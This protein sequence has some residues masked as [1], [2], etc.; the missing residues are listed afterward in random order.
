MKISSVACLALVVAPSATTAWSVGPSSSRQTPKRS[1]PSPSV[2]MAAAA[3]ASAFWIATQA[4]FGWNGPVVDGPVSS[5][6]PTSSS[7]V[8]AGGAYVPEDSYSSLD[9]SMPKYNTAAT[10]ELILTPT[11]QTK[12]AVSAPSAK[13]KAASA[14]RMAQDPEKEAA[15]LA[16]AQQKAAAQAAQARAQAQAAREKQEAIQAKMEA[17]KAE[18]TA[19]QQVR[20]KAKGIVVAEE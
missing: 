19:M 1:P 4:A 10:N 16:L 9:L 7:I 18:R 5:P 17:K 3:T 14:K 6:E 12:K 11:A 13:D 2:P 20:L 15:R 8:L